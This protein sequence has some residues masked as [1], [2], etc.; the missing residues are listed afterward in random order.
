MIFL[1]TTPQM[2][3]VKEHLG[4]NDGQMHE[5]SNNSTCI[6]K[7]TTHLFHTRGKMFVLVPFPATTSANFSAASACFLACRAPHPTI[8]L[9]MGTP[10]SHQPSPAL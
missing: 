2:Q 10:T 6:I 8:K 1:S 7:G 3:L 5:L 4:K 9:S